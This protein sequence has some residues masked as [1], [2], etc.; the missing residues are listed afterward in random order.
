MNVND[1]LA[2]QYPFPP[3]W[4]LVADVLMTERAQSVLDY[5]TINSSIRSIASLFTLS[6]HKSAHGFTRLPS[7]IDYCVVLMGKSE[8]LGLTH[9]GVYYE[10]GVLHALE[11]GAQY[12]PMSVIGDTYALVE[13]WGKP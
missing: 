2:K 5:K 1:Y 3:C 8:K 12:Q 13:F 4:S 6:L 7:P 9:A 11:S 10:G